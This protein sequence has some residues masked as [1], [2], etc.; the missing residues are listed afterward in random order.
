MVRKDSMDNTDV[1]SMFADIKTMLGTNIQGIAS[2]L[3]QVN[4]AVAEIQTT[5][6]LNEQERRTANEAFKEHRDLQK[7][8]S[9]RLQAVEAK[10]IEQQ[11]K[12]KGNSPWLSALIAIGTALIVV[13][14][15][16]YL[17]KTK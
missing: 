3:K 5:L 12:E 15:K 1:S 9:V 16:D 8:L 6:K 2:E 17:V 11:G 14:I 13:I 4:I 10:L 7:D